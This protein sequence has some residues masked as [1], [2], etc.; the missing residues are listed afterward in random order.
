MTVE[1]QNL[2]LFGSSSESVVVDVKQEGI[3]LNSPHK[4]LLPMI[5]CSGYLSLNLRG[6][7]PSKLLYDKSTDDIW[8][9][10][11]RKSGMVPERLLWERFKN[12]RLVNSPRW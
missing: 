7:L 12:S 6:I 11:L 9:M 5:A 10:E 1:K 4:P 2:S 3:P 8:V